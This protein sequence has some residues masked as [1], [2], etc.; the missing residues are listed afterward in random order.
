[1]NADGPY[2]PEAWARLTDNNVGDFTATW[3]PDGQKIVFHR[4]VAGRAQLWVMNANGT[5]QTQLT[6]TMGLNLL[7]NWGVPRVKV[8]GF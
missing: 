2:D 8:E 7:A 6:N 3:S 1:M 4:L 5:A